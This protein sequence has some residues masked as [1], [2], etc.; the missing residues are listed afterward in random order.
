MSDVD[1]TLQFDDVN[2]VAA[3]VLAEMQNL[4]LRKAD[5]D[6]YSQLYLHLPGSAGL[7]GLRTLDEL[8]NHDDS[9]AFVPD[10]GH[11]VFD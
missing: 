5:S 1:G 10:Y 6:S 8:V 4:S 2:E 9:H 7:L 3:A 11:S